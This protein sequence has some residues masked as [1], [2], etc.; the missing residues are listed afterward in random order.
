MNRHQYGRPS[1]PKIAP[2]A[3]LGAEE[4]QQKTPPPEGR[5]RRF[6]VHDI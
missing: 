6:R 5:K 1:W 3:T 2:A 4:A